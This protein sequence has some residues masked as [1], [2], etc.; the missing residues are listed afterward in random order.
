MLIFNRVNILYSCFVF[1]SLY[2]SSEYKG[3]VL[4]NKYFFDNV[5]KSIIVIH[6]TSWTET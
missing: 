1:V 5:W 2:H 6:N 3:N 4:V